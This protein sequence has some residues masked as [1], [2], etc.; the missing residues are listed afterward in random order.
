MWVFYQILYDFSIQKKYT[1]LQELLS[2]AKYNEIYIKAFV[3][4]VLATDST[5]LDSELKKKITSLTGPQLIKL[6]EITPEKYKLLI[7]ISAILSMFLRNGEFHAGEKLQR[8]IMSELLA[9]HSSE[10]TLLLEEHYEKMQAI[11]RF[12]NCPKINK[13]FIDQIILRKVHFFKRVE[14]ISHFK[15]CHIFRKSYATYFSTE[16]GSDFKDVVKKFSYYRRFLVKYC[17]DMLTLEQCEV[18]LMNGYAVDG[19]QSRQRALADRLLTCS[20]ADQKQII[21]NRQLDLVQQPPSLRV[22]NYLGLRFFPA[23]TLKILPPA[24]DAFEYQ[25]FIRMM[26]NKCHPTTAPAA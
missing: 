4:K 9:L 21:L 5:D 17:G 16:K 8:A 19:H 3:E 18:I 22:V 13:F 2:Q 14:G 11:A 15:D 6:I 12:C 20:D 24:T 25:E 10:L 1:K 26:C 23:A 7:R